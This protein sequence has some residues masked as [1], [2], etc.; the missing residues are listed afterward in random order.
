MNARAIGVE[1]PR[2][3]P[4]GWAA[5]LVHHFLLDAAAADAAAVAVEDGRWA[6][7]YGELREAS[8]GYANSLWAAGIRPGDPVALRMEPCVE[9]VVAI[10]AL[11][12][13]GAVYVPLNPEYPSERVA[14]MLA[15]AEPKL[16]IVAG[17]E[18]EPPDPDLPLGVAAGSL[19]EIDG[20]VPAERRGR[21]APVLETD[22]AYVIFTSGTTG[23]PKGIMI[24]HRAALAFWRAAVDHC[25]LGPGDRV[26]TLAPLSFDFSLID[27]GIALGSGATLVQV[28]RG[29]MLRPAHCAEFL[30]SRRVTQ[31]DAV[32]SAWR[33]LM[34]HAA[35][36]LSELSGLHTGFYAG[37]GFPVPDLLRLRELLPELRIV[38]CFGHTESMCCTFEDLPL[39]LP[40][41]AE[42]V[43]IGHAHP[44]AELLLI[45]EDGEE[46]TEPGVVGEM[47]LRGA[48]LFSGYWR[49][50]EATRRALVENPLRPG[51]GEL[52]FRTSDLAS[53]GTDGKLYYAG[54]KDLQV[55]I[56]GIR[57]EVEEIERVVDLHP[58]IAESAVV[59]T[60]R[61]GLP[62]LVA[63]V[64]VAAG[65]EAPSVAELRRF[66]ADRLPAFMLPAELRREDSLPVNLNGKVDRGALRERLGAA[67]GEAG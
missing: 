55:Q 60:E 50:A 46:V 49:D 1:A 63:G 11:S 6:I 39:P 59:L 3:Y 40:A 12:Q 62:W 31:L 21:E 16:C 22:V 67:Q 61:D 36:E 9:A 35:A 20:E 47:Y 58:A 4:P 2:S 7:T 8:A 42:A 13:L 29:L 38:N 10:C 32:P 56:M 30:H 54:R 51:G 23:V 48:S 18:P 17:A 19:L 37:E 5:V 44:G 25:R 53:R 41:T 27:I 52:V 65:Q 64:V 15:A 14:A 57:T 43:P 28:P 33:L 45:D 26:A 66:C 34:R 24:S